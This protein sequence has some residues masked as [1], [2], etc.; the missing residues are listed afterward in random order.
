MLAVLLVF[1]MALLIS[2]NLYHDN[3]GFASVLSV[4]RVLPSRAA[5]ALLT[6]EVSQRYVFISPPGP[7]CQIEL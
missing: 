1:V 7:R 3:E 6:E 2:S 4:P 5:A